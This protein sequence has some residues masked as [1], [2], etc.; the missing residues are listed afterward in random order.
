MTQSNR[1]ELLHIGVASLSFAFLTQL[2]WA[3]AQEDGSKGNR[4]LPNDEQIETAN[5]GAT[6]RIQYLEMVSPD[7]EAICKTYEQLH[8]V[9]FSDPVANLGNART[10]TLHDGSILGIRAPLR[11]NE[12]P[13][14]RPYFL[15]ED[16]ESAV[17]KAAEAGAEVALPPM[18]LADYGTCAILIQG[19]IEHGLWQN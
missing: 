13:V 16:I 3:R 19:G 18:K 6:M 9:K 15:V 7:V 4:V 10:T 1:R 8:G 12:T 14:V 17:A 5:P 11:G 2:R